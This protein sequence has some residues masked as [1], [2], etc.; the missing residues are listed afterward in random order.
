MKYFTLLFCIKSPKLMSD[1]RDNMI[2][3]QTDVDGFDTSCGRQII[4]F[5]TKITTSQTLKTV[6]A[7]LHG[8]K[9]LFR[10]D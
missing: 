7:N 9:G 1:D 3:S 2:N 10:C 5:S 4:T 6:N 8:N